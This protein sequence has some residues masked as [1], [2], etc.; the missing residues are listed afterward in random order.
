[1]VSNKLLHL[2]YYNFE[3]K[4]PRDTDNYEKPTTSF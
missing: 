1:M 2:N 3:A 4:F